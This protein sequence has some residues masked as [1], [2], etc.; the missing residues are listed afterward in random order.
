ML[1]VHD[2][3]GVQE[4]ATKIQLLQVRPGEFGHGEERGPGRGSVVTSRQLAVDVASK[5]LPFNP[6]LVTLDAL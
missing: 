5:S 1:D 6:S 3:R 2:L 4:A